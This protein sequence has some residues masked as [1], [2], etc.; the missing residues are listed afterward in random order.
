M[1]TLKRYRLAKREATIPMPDRGGRLFAAD[2]AGEM[3]DV[4]NRFYGTLIR[5]GDIVPV[6]TRRAAARQSSN[7]GKR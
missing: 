6:S 3:V 2:D 1:P 4:E 7:K 5:D